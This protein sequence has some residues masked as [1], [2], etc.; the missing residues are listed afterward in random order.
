MPFFIRLAYF[1]PLILLVSG[2]ATESLEFTDTEKTA[3]NIELT[4]T[5]FY[6]QSRYQ[7]G[8]T[9]LATV[10]NAS[11]LNIDPDDLTDE[12]YLPNR[13]GSLQIEMIASVRRNG[14]IPY[15]TGGEMQQVINLLQDG[16]PVLVLLN[17]GLQG[18][19]VYHYAVVIG[20]SSDSDAV[21]LRSGTDFRLLMPRRRFLSAWHKADS[22][23]L[24]VLPPGK[25][26]AS[27]DLQRYL[28]ATME[29]ESTGQWQAAEV[30][31]R[32]VLMRWPR[33]TLARF[34]LA[35]CLRLQGK[36]DK[37]V[38]E[39]QNILAHDVNHT[40]ARNN[41]ADTLLRLNRCDDAVAAIEPAFDI[42]STDSVVDRTIRETYLEIKSGCPHPN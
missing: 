40:Q 4:A 7:C 22:W 6:P 8:P 17:L 25:L 26:P 19:P 39:Y 15:E 37:A 10:L 29:M 12:V 30:S 18:L 13:K 3:K 42:S 38:V 5:P 24:T 2:C 28:K 36:L 11:G 1:L 34:G 41:L 14:R 35:N 31:Y 23:A 33:N 32:A 21:I 20:F 16:L 9:S 27:I